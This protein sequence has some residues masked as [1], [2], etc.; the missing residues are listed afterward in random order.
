MKIFNPEMLM[1]GAGASPLCQGAYPV[2]PDVSGNL[3]CPLDWG[4][5]PPCPPR[6]PFDPDPCPGR[7]G[8][9]SDR[10]VPINPES[11]YNRT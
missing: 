5:V 3:P 2:C 6:V 10:Y 9:C 8:G 4:T 7:G 1:G 11:M